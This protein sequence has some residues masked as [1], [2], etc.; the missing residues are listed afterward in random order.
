[1]GL[2]RPDAP[3]DRTECVEY[4]PGSTWPGGRLLGCNYFQMD[5][6]AGAE[7]TS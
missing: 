3:S 4:S 1:M 5:I 6:V 7:L 2:L